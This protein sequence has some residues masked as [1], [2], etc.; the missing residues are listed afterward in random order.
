MPILGIV[1]LNAE[2][3]MKYRSDIIFDKF[4]TRIIG[5]RMYIELTAK[6]VQERLIN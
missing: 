6:G 3:Y 5:S 2:N 4:Q 1:F